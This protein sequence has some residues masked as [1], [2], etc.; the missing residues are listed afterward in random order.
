[1]AA[2]VSGVPAPTTNPFPPSGQLASSVVDMATFMAMFFGTRPAGGSQLLVPSSI[3]E[4]FQPVINTEGAGAVGIGWFIYPYNQY[5]L[6]SKN[7]AWSGVFTL[8][9]MIPE[10]K[11][12]IVVL[13]SLSPQ[14][15]S[16]PASPAKLD[17]TIFS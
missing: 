9:R 12:G 13:I 4:M 15:V 17:Q 7:G 14:Q 1:M 6:V 16:G 5:T 10:L 8:V 2:G 11:L 3:Q